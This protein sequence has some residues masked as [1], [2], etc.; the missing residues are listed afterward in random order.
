M[1]KAKEYY[2]SISDFIRPG[3]GKRICKTMNHLTLEDVEEMI[4]K[5]Q[6]YIPDYDGAGGSELYI[7]KNEILAKLKTQKL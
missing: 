6:D 2:N 3:Q 4:D 7:N 1:S 5:A